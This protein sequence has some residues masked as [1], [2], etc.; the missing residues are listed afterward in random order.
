M[1]VP[2]YEYGIDEPLGSEINVTGHCG[3]FFSGGP[4]PIG[5]APSES[6]LNPR[7]IGFVRDEFYIPV[8]WEGD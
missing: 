4:S 6:L 7:R 5:E 2:K 1:I 3:G 8:Y